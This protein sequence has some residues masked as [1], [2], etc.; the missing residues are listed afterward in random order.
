MPCHPLSQ[1][2][3]NSCSIG[4][5]LHK[6]DD[7]RAPSRR[8]GPQQAGPPLFVPS[9]HWVPRCAFTE[10]PETS[11]HPAKTHEAMALCQTLGGQGIRGRDSVGHGEAAHVL[12]ESEAWEP[13]RTARTP[14]SPSC[15]ACTHSFPCLSFCIDDTGIITEPVSEDCGQDK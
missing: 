13:D 1:M 6:W 11:V 4:S 14:S 5:I 10:A 3:P 7:G 8:G 15:A 12:V 9:P 2:P